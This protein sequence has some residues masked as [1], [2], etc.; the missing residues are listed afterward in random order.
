M[1]NKLAFKR[2]NKKARFVFFAISVLLPGGVIPG[3]STATTTNS[4]TAQPPVIEAMTNATTAQP[5]VADT[6]TNSAAVVSPPT[7]KAKPSGVYI[8]GKTPQERGAALLAYCATVKPRSNVYGKG[9]MFYYVARILTKT[10]TEYAISEWQKNAAACLANALQDID[11]PRTHGFENME[12]FDKHMLVWSWIVC[13]DK[14]KLPPDIEENTKKYVALYRHKE[15]KGYDA[16]NYRLMMDGSGFL[17]AEQ[18]PELVDADGLNAEQ[19][20]QATKERL[21]GYFHNITVNNFHE[22]GSPVYGGIDIVIMKMLAEV[23]QDSEV[24]QAASKA[25]DAMF[26]QLAA[27]WNNGYLITSAG[28]AKNWSPADGSPDN[29]GGQAA[30][31]A[32]VFW[33]ADRPINAYSTGASY[34]GWFGV[35]GYTPPPIAEKIAHDRSVPV[36]YRESFVDKD[37]QVRITIYQAPTYGV[38]SQWEAVDSPTSGFCKENKREMFKWISDK[39]ASSFIPLQEN[40]QKAYDKSDKKVN[41]SGWGENPYTQVLQSEGTLIAVCKVDDSYPYWKIYAPF[42]TKGAIVKRIEKDGWVFCHGGSVLFAFRTI[43]PY[44]WGRHEQDS[45]VLWSD[46]RT[47]GWI[48]ETSPVAPYAGGGVDAELDRFAAAVGAKVRVDSSGLTGDT[49]NL[50]VTNLAGRNLDLTFRPLGTSY[51]DQHQVD[52]VVINYQAFPLIETRQLVQ[53][54]GDEQQTI[55][56]IP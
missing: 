50:K 44:T 25:L 55:K 38:A 22:Y 53:Q 36:S 39:P 2:L 34:A 1:S 7:P 27:A 35:P 6:T 21:M 29:M 5:P 49:P 43:K 51:T 12:P 56:P 40:L 42:T 17:A 15:W 16:L 32:W 54:V 31:D 33:G 48:L 46:D 14:V 19:I 11:K 3:D 8:D 28:R 47:N 26:I 41:P 13:H 9:D 24:R 20:K 10:D 37:Q 45:D 23:P 52:G 4:V 30:A 18:W